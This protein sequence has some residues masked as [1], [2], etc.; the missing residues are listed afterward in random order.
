[1][2][3][4]GQINCANINQITN[5]QVQK[6]E[7]IPKEILNNLDKMGVDSSLILNSC[8]G[9]YLNFVFKI[10]VK[11]FDLIGKKVG[12]LH[13]GKK[14]KKDYFEDERERFYR[15][16][17]TVNGTLYIFDD[18]Q[19]KES[20]GYDAAIVYWSKFLLPVKDVANRLKCKYPQKP[21]KSKME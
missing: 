1:M 3:T 7:E 6:F 14:N 11:D 2:N 8:E 15:N 9:T 18:S 16:Y 20:G 19:K 21:C 17:T 10:S 4:L 12:F 5:R 13:A